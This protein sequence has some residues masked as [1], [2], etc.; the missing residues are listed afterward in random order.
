MV[1]SALLVLSVV[2]SV[3]ASAQNLTTPEAGTRIRV[4]IA[5][6]S[7]NAGRYDT[8]GL[9]V[10]R[11]DSAIVLDRGTDGLDTIPA[12][13]VRRID[14]QT[15]TRSAGTNFLRGTIFGA[16]IGGGLGLLLGAAAHD[17]YSCSDGGFCVTAAGGALMGGMLGTAVGS[18]IGLMYGPSEQWQLGE[19]LSGIRAT[20]AH[21]GSLML[22]ISIM[23]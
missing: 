6:D 18:L 20:P 1:R 12:S 21:D 8:K 7:P 23:R 16:T 10:V 4:V 15:S 22:G 3:P 13:L 9:F 17:S 19:T 5:P 11:T 2:V 14:L